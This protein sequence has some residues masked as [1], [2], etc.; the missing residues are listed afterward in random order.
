MGTKV[1]KEQNMASRNKARAIDH[2]LVMDIFWDILSSFFFYNIAQCF[3]NLE[4]QQTIRFC[5]LHFSYIVYQVLH[6]VLA[7]I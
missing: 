2:V 3:F 7:K 5:K 4:Q 1:G 6:N